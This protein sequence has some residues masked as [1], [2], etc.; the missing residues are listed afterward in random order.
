M[1]QDPNAIFIYVITLIGLIHYLKSISALKKVFK[2]AP[3]IIWIYF[4]PMLSSGIGIIPTDSSLYSWT[5]KYLLPPALILLLLSSNVKILSTLGSKAIGTM[6]FGTLGIVLGGP[7]SL[8]IFGSFLPEDAWMGLAALSGSWIG[9]SANMVAIGKSIGT[10]DNLFGNMIVIDTV[11]GYGWMGIVILISG[12]QK[13]IDKWNNADTRIIDELNIKMNTE[14]LKR[15]TSFNDLLTI[16]VVSLFFGLF[17]LELGKLI[18]DLGK[19]I[20]S[21]GWTIILVSLIGISLSF[22]RLSELNN[23]G[24]SHVGNLFLYILL[25]TIGAKA[26]ITQIADLPYYIAVGVFWIFI[27][28]IILFFGGRL[29]RAPMFLIATS[30]QAN[31]GGVVSAPIIAT[32]Y[33]KSL[34]P[35]GLLMG[36]IGNIIGIYAGLFTAWL[37]SLVGGIYY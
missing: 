19:V 26:N 33:K 1:I 34:A 10:S 14:D 28:A 31:I 23:A 37:L 25:G 13:R 12:H 3:P 36:V 18:P 2:Y 27:H 8:L 35:V 16:V 24:A 9:G 32:V 4:L 6:L 15:P 11:V 5:S 17:S 22:T 20:T 30:S 7:I 21:F 29:L